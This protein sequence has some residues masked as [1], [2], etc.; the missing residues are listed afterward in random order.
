MGGEL[1][2]LVATQMRRVFLLCGNGEAMYDIDHVVLGTKNPQEFLVV[3]I[4]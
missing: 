4:L 3:A 1:T 2:E